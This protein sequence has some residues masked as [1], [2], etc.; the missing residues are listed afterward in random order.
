MN[1]E[2]PE[3]VFPQRLAQAR[4]MRGLSLRQLSEATGN[5]VSHNALNR[6]EKGVMRP[7]S[8]VLVA[9]AEALRQSPEFF[10]R[11]FGIELKGIKFRK[12][13]RLAGKEQVAIREQALDYFE[14]YLEIEQILAIAAAFENP[15]ETFKIKSCEDVEIAAEKLRSAWELGEAPLASVVEIVE[16]R[17]I[18]IFEVVAPE[19]F[20]GFSGRA[21]GYPIVVS[22][23]WMNKDLPRKRFT[24]LHEVAHLLLR[25]LQSV[26]DKS[27]EEEKFCHRFAAAMLIPRN[28]FR[29]E[30]GGFRRHLSLE[31]LKDIKA[32]YGISIA[33]IVQRAADLE[34]ISPALLKGFHIKRNTSGWHKNE[35]GEYEGRETATRFE[36]LVLRATAEE[37][38][39]L[40]KAAALLNQPL[41][42]VRAKLDGLA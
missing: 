17:G 22:A 11:P 21:D 8:E 6:Y 39:S 3:L 42:T 7:G 16:A 34:M 5:R 30:L 26:A 10:F 28:I 4:R 18:K 31:E 37:T 1:M 41:P 32:R 19:S 9:V 24:V 20:S 27:K 14:R 2:R 36:Q 38:I 13:S 23:K 40:S 15:L 29:A 35:P 25:L 12:M 33:A